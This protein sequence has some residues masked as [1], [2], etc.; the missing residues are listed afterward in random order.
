MATHSRIFAWK[1]PWTEESGGLQ[2]M[3]SPRDATKHAGTQLRED[4]GSDEGALC[5]SVR[6]SNLKK[7]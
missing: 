3:R 7:Y 4:G 6:C 5:G 1:I 2:S